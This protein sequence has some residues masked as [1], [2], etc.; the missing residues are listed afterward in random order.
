MTGSDHQTG[1]D[2]IAEAAAGI[3]CDIVV[4]IQGDEAFVRPEHVDAGV[5]ELRRD[6]SVQV[7]IL[8]TPY[9]KYGEASDIKVVVNEHNDVMYLSR[10]DI[11]SGAR[12]PNPEMLKGYHVLA[13][14]KHFLLEYS[15]WPRGR[16]E[17]I[18]FHEHL[19]ILERGER[20]RAVHVDSDA[21]SVDTSD[22]LARARARMA[23]DS[24]LG[25]YHALG[26]RSS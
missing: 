24:L 15:R 7:T 25:L 11:P 6:P 16:L 8:V 18:E 9:R 20:I 21:T 19:R 4:N 17:V 22:D 26:K 2:R 12:T 14:R 10:S 23:D 1:T 5:Q 3:D 13:F